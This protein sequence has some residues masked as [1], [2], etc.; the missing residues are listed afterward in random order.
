M[1]TPNILYI[2]Y[3]H[4]RKDSTQTFEEENPEV[5]NY[6]GEKV[7]VSSTDRR[8]NILN[9]L[10]PRRHCK[11]YGADWKNCFDWTKIIGEFR[12]R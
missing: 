3:Q 5:N 12:R 4:F 9:G 7:S 8:G 11:L 1:N 10:R 6:P 2:N